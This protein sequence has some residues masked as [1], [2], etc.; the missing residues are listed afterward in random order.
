MLHVKYTP[1]TSTLICQAL[2]L[3]Q[4]QTKKEMHAA[5]SGCKP[6]THTSACQTT[7]EGNLKPYFPPP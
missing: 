1:I 2:C 5:A 4:P 3:A 6:T 7:G